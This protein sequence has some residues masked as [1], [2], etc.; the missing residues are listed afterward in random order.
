MTEFVHVFQSETASNGRV[1]HVPLAAMRLGAIAMRLMN[2]AVARQIRAGIG[3]DIRPQ[4]FDAAAKWRLLITTLAQVMQRDFAGSASAARAS[5]AAVPP[6]V[7]GEGSLTGGV[8]R[9]QLTADSTRRRFNPSHQDPGRARRG[10][11]RSSSSAA[12]A[13]T[14]APSRAR[15]TIT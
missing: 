14:R 2:P 1:G 10:A 13:W 9:E 12:R 5:V 15:L 11:A 6:G 4:A 3:M 8:R 7:E